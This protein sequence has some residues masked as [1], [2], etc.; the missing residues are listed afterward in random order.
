MRTFLCSV[1]VAAASLSCRRDGPTVLFPPAIVVKEHVAEASR[2]E[3]EL[4]KR[5]NQPAPA[6][7]PWF[8]VLPGES[9]VLI[10]AGHATAHARESGVK[11]AD[12]GTGSLAFMINRL[13][14]CPTI[15]TTYQS[16]RDP[17]SCNDSE[18]KAELKSLI[19]RHRPTI[20]LDLHASNVGRPYDIDFGTMG[21]TS[22]L[23]R[24]DL[25]ERLVEHLRRESMRNFSQDYFAASAQGRV[26]RFVSRMGV[27]CVQLEVNQN[28]LITTSERGVGTAVQNQR[29]AQLLQ[30]IVRFAR[31]VD[32][33]S[34]A[35]GTRLLPSKISATRPSG[36]TT[37][38]APV[39]TASN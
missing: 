3:G 15:M 39:G 33:Q 25:L 21:G 1:V 30:A 23:R 7:Q 29:F 27:P 8:E 16:P 11:E 14:G 5:Y 9:K 22:L 28:W 32:D 34:A 13:A 20:V 24:G 10:V 12:A 31:E 2:F 17:N 36:S 35:T 6:T 4:A 38:A 19:E 18:F 26:T 37:T